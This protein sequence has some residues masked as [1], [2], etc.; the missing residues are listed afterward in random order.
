M[1][2]PPPDT[3]RAGRAPCRLVS[4]D[5]GWTLGAPRGPSLT[6]RLVAM[7]VLPQAE[8]KRIVQRHLHVADPTQAVVG[9]MCAQL[10]IDPARFPR[11][12]TPPEFAW[13]PGAREAVAAIAARA[14][15]VTMSNVC[16]HDEESAMSVTDALGPHLSAHHPSWRLGFAKPDPRALAAVA[17]LHHVAPGELIHVG[18]SLDYDVAGALGAGARAVWITRSRP[19]YTTG[20]PDTV[21]VVPD[22]GA[23]VEH[24]LHEI[25]HSLPGKEP[26]R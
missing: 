6:R 2:K 11:D 14:P 22:L 4:L 3:A 17:A 25:A 5:V 21:T 18:D 8:A 15:V 19:R 10:G 1:S 20:L 7:S 23:A 24:V 12:H 26:P 9:A 13:W 16:R